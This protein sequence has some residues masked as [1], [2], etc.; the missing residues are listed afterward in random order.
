M[1]TE[2]LIERLTALNTPA[3][4][5]SF[6]LERGDDCAPRPYCAE[7]AKILCD[8]LRELIVAVAFNAPPP[9]AAAAAPGEEWGIVSLLG[10]CTFAG[11]VTEEERFGAK[12]GRCDIPQPDGSFVTR[13][14]PGASLYSYV[15]CTKEA[16][17]ARAGALQPPA[18]LLNL[19]AT[20]PEDG[21]YD[22]EEEE[23]PL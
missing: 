20:P 2:I 5:L 1:K 23:I 15:P 22:D 11:R 16:A 17:M 12:L 9:A 4:E 6:Q 7:Q 14:F 3:L 18:Q 10:H 13:Y 8:G 19:P 21:G